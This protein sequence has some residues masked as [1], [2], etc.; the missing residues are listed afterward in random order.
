MF[1]SLFGQDDIFTRESK[2]VDII[3]IF[4][5]RKLFEVKNVLLIDLSIKSILLASQDINGIF[6]SGTQLFHSITNE[7]QSANYSY[8]PILF[9]E[10]FVNLFALTQAPILVSSLNQTYSLSK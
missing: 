4:T 10:A 8:E 7:L 3:L 6:T 5:W 9:N 1:L 2:I